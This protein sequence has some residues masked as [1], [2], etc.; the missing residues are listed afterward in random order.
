MSL[1]VIVRAKLV[2]VAP[3]FRSSRYK[4]SVIQ[5]PFGHEGYHSLLANPL[6]NKGAVLDDQLG[7][8]LKDI[9]KIE[10]TQG[11]SPKSQRVIAL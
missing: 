5:N 4:H 1:S 6:G 11:N 9:A 10:A 8:S 7:V 3:G 2:Q